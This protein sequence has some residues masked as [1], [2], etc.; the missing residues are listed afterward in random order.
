M[1]VLPARTG[2]AITLNAGDVL[3]IRNTHGG[4]VV[5]TWFLAASEPTR[6]FVATAMTW[7][8]SG[9]LYL[10]EG[11]ELMDTSRVPIAR[12]IQDTSPGAH[13]MLVPSCD[14]ARYRQLGASGYHQNCHDNFLEALDRLQVSAPVVVPAPV[15]L[16]MNV[17]LAT[18]GSFEIA[19][20]EAQE[21]DDVRIAALEN[22]IVVM[23]ACPQD[24][25]ATNGVG[26][27]PR[28]VEYS[29]CPSR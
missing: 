26:T 7:M 29:V 19:A 10:R 11:D 23:S 21:G 5:D 6:R 13:D 1:K 16:F 8:R 4:Q 22:L 20:P 3:T 24:M 2:V 27:T 12:L 18:D 17:P 9:R 28:E 15:N 25:A 14:T